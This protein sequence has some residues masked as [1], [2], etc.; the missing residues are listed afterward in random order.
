M[1]CEKRK[2]AAQ[3][4]KKFF[5]G[6]EVLPFTQM[7]SKMG[8]HTSRLQF[9]PSFLVKVLIESLPIGSQQQDFQPILT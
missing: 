4:E 5:N 7:C 8:A 3:T 6:N 1:L 2:R 9:R